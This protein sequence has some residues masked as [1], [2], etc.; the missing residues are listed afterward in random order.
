MVFE[1]I[2][3]VVNALEVG[4][5]AMQDFETS[6]PGENVM[7]K[8]NGLSERRRRELADFLRTRREKLKPEVVGLNQFVRRR[9][10]G[11][12]REEVADRAGV[13]T[14]W[15]TWLEQAR[16]IQPSGDVLGRLATALML[17]SVETKHLY[18]LAGKTM[19]SEKI[20]FAE[21]VPDSLIAFLENALA[22][23]AIL[24]GSRWDLLALNTP[25]KEI[26]PALKSYSQI[27]KVNWLNFIFGP[28]MKRYVGVLWP[29]HARRLLAEFRAS[30]I[31]TLDTDWFTTFIEKMK[32]E[33]HEFAQWWREHDVRD[34]PTFPVEFINEKTGEATAFLRTAYRP[35]EDSRFR[36]IVFNPANCN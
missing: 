5:E 31:E 3:L 29:A 22:V 14:T 19:P 25:A 7:T 17:S 6:L 15:Y 34:I 24:I 30:A 1:T 8:Q 2:I 28:E 27:D 35:L 11:L 10:P 32:S 16:D 33:S 4:A 13:G 18:S 12:R 23:P 36:V 26:F 21:Q 20:A 9:T